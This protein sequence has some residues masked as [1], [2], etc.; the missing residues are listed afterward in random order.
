MREPNAEIGALIQK[1]R[2]D[3]KLSLRA[4]AS[5]A[6]VDHTT[7]MRLERGEDVKLSVFVK[8]ATEAGY[9]VMNRIKK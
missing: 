4:F 8:S 1:A 5:L 6:D 3:R 7:L 2:T 9:S